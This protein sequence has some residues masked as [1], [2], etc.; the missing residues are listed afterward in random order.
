[1][2]SS[3]SKLYAPFRIKFSL[4]TAQKLARGLRT[5]LK[6]STLFENQKFRFHTAFDWLLMTQRWMHTENLLLAIY[7]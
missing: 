6:S 5:K 1:M 2:T 4:Q 3:V 7:V